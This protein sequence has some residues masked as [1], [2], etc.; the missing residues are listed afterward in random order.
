M[1]KIVEVMEL[2]KSIKA[3][4]DNIVKEI[5]SDIDNNPIDGYKPLGSNCFT[6][7]FST[8]NQHDV[9]SPEYYSPHKQAEYVR[10]YLE[11]ASTATN[12]VNRITKLVNERQIKF[13]YGNVARLNDKT[14][15]I[16]EKYIKNYVT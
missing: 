8:L 13:S 3:M 15:E 2:E 7:K 9:W 11:G 1:N 14:I 5:E 6:V 16:L 10:S 12:F 4:I